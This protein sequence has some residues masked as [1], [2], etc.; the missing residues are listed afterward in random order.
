MENQNKTVSSK[1]QLWHLLTYTNMHSPTVT[2]SRAFASK[3][4]IT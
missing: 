4:N 3:F 2:E 1:K